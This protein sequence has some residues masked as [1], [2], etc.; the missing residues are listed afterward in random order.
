MRGKADPSF[1][2]NAR[3]RPPLRGASGKEGGGTRESKKH[4]SQGSRR[5]GREPSGEDS[6]P[7][8]SRPMGDV[9]IG[10]GVPRA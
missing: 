10:N 9:M 5:G 2:G 7:A 3:S 6:P 4:M 8:I 1:K